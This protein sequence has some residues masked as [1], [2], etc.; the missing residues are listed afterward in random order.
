MQIKV[1]DKAPDFSIPDADMNLIRRSQF[2]G[3]NNL[4]LYFYVRDDTPG[5]TVQ[6]IEFPNWNRNS[7]N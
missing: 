5:C 1:G 6:G 3:H 2:K 7:R 4:V